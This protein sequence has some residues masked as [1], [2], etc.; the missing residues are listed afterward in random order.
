[1]LAVQAACS[2]LRG[3]GSPGAGTG[4]AAAIGEASGIGEATGIGEAFGMGVAPG[5]L[6]DDTISYIHER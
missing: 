5:A 1:M 2:G 3:P 4:T 6:I